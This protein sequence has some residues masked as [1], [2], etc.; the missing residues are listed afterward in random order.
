MS[1]EQETTIEEIDQVVNGNVA[2]DV[3]QLVSVLSTANMQF[4][5]AMSRALHASIGVACALSLKERNNCLVLILEGPPGI[6]K[7][8]A[9]RS[10]EPV[11]PATKKVLIRKDNFTTASFVSHASIG[12]PNNFRK[13]TCC[14]SSREDNSHERTRDIIWCG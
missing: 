4:G 5:K 8:E 3:N 11:R 10:L 9:V 14:P 12:P 7:S 2:D 1:V 6:G 13:T